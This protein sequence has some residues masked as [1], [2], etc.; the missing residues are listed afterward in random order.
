MDEEEKES[1][2]EREQ[3]MK[4]ELSRNIYIYRIDK[5][6]SFPNLIFIS[7]VLLDISCR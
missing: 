1:K 7:A 3:E 5:L 6:S 2:R 4:R